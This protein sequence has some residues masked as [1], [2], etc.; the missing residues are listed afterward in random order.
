MSNQGFI[1][2]NMFFGKVPGTGQPAAMNQTNREIDP[3]YL[4]AMIN[5][6]NEHPE[7]RKNAME[8]KKR[9][10]P[11][12]VDIPKQENEPVQETPPEPKPESKPKKKVSKK[13]KSAAKKVQK[14]DP[15]SN[16]ITETKQV[17]AVEFGQFLS[18]FSSQVYS[19]E[20]HLL[21]SDEHV[22]QLKS[23]TVEE[24]KYLSKQLEIFEGRSRDLDKDDEDYLHKAQELEFA[25][26]NA[27][28]VVLRRCIVNN[29]P[30]ENLTIYDWVYLL[31]YT[32]LM[33][34]GEEANFKVTI[35]DPEPKPKK[36]VSK[37][38]KGDEKKVEY[39]DINLSELLDHLRANRNLF[40]QNPIGYVDVDE[41]V[42]LY[43]MMPTRGDMLYVQQEC[44]RNPNASLSILSIAMC[45]KA[46]VQ[47]GVANIMSPDQRIQLV[48]SLSYDHLRQI[49]KAYDENQKAFFGTINEWVKTYNES[50]GGFEISDFILF[51]Y[52]F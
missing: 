17:N 34:R 5:N 12:M 3:A 7:I 27:L 49:S 4:D 38:K 24:Y 52:D 43:L 8:M 41:N 14:E 25:L 16:P 15:P 28:D 32:R 51:F 36:K 40:I 44:L 46:Y 42:G 13:K 20:V 45:V 1:D 31:V 19:D 6:P 10:F 48:N 18:N 11:D 22:I 50:A 37:K 39:I 35:E 23:M 2:D 29:F 47:D 33:S 26:T 30:I 21:S 9:L